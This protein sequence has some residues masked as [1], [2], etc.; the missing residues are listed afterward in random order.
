M[1]DDLHSRFAVETFGDEGAFSH[2]RHRGDI[3]AF[4]GTG[5]EL[6]NTDATPGEAPSAPRVVAHAL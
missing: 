2:I 5:G 6:I 4:H 3:R 1:M